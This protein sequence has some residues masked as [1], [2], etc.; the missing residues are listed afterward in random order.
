MATATWTHD[1]R[2]LAHGPRLVAL[3]AQPGAVHL[4][5]SGHALDVTVDPRP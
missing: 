1:G 4:E 5:A 2:T 3:F